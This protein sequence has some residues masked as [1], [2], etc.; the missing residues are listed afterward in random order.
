MHYIKAAKA[1]QYK[2]GDYTVHSLMGKKIAIIC[3]E[4]GFKAMEIKCKHQGALLLPNQ[5][6]ELHGDTLVCPRH[7]WEYDIVSG[8]CLS[9]DSVPLRQ[10]PVD[11]RDGN[12]F[13]GFELE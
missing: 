13:V 2:K 10:F 8:N 3:Q 7:G 1:D 12:L 5:R 9:N 6:G 4:D 11:I